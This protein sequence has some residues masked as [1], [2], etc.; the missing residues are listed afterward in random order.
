VQ[1][2]PE[3][4]LRLGELPFR[5]LQVGLS[6]TAV[7]GYVNEWTV[8]IT[9]I[10]PTV[11]LIRDLIRS[12]DDPAA[13]ALLPPEHPYPLP[14]H[15]GAAIGASPPEPQSPEPQSPDVQLRDLTR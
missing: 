13:S 5:S 6:G 9:D 10:T 3:R 7:A 1:W 14:S 4:S 12:E 8:A 15:L 11:H 2:D